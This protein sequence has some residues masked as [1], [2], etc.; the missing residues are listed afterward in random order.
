[1]RAELPKSHIYITENL[2]EYAEELKEQVK[3]HRCVSYIRDDFLIE[4][5][6]AVIGEAY[7][8]E[9]REKFLILGAKSFNAISQ[10][11]LLK[12]IEEPPKN[13]V[14]I[15]LAPSKSLFL[16]TIRSRLPMINLKH[17]EDVL[18]LDISLAR[19][20]IQA[21]FS[22]VK[23]HEQ[24]KRHDLQQLIEQMYHHACV[25]EAM[26]LNQEQLDAFDLAYRLIPLNGRSQ[27]ILVMLLMSFVPEP[28]RGR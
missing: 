14:F 26:A 6:K 20:D 21:L 3:P 24:L 9:E 16:P 23:A 17:R 12:I 5:A 11:S 15:L 8:S 13:I 2:H 18:A 25:N 19:L 10:N 1:M 28:R 27:S 22:F 7:I 4:D